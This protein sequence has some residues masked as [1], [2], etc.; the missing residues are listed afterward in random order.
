MI[1]PG[2]VTDFTALTDVVNVV[3]KL[4]GANDDKYLVNS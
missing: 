1:E 3:V 2:E 4:P